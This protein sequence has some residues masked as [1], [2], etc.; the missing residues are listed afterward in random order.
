[1]STSATI[2]PSSSET[3]VIAGAD[4]TDLQG[5]KVEIPPG[6]LDG[7]PSIE[8]HFT[9]GEEIANDTTAAYLTM[10]TPVTPVSIPADVSTEDAVVVNREIWITLPLTIDS[11]QH[12]AQLANPEQSMAIFYLREH[13]FGLAAE[14]GALPGSLIEVSPDRRFVRFPV[15]FFGMMQIGFVSEPV[16]AP[17]RLLVS[18][19][20][21]LATNRVMVEMAQIY[22][23]QQDIF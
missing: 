14:T 4:G 5:A 6:S 18:R 23:T 20:E 16:V 1:M 2:A 7:D 9:Y 15:E 17:V 3:Q 19:Q 11:N 13:G 8:V 10:P 21:A 22:S 12:Q